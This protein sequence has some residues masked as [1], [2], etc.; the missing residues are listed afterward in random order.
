MI[1]RKKAFVNA[2]AGGRGDPSPFR[3]VSAPD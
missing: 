3:A 2:A 1:G